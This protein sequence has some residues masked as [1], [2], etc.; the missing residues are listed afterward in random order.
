M[1][2]ITTIFSVIS[3]P[4][5]A[6]ELKNLNFSRPLYQAPTP[7][8]ASIPPPEILTDTSSIYKHPEKTAAIM[9]DIVI[10]ILEQIDETIYFSYLE[11]LTA[12]GPR[13]TGSEACQAAADYIYNQF[14]SM[15]LAVRYHHWSVG[16]HTSDNVEATINGIDESSDEIYIICAHYDT[17]S[18]SMGADDDASGTV[19]VLMAALIMSQQHYQFNH[20][21]K[22]VAFSGEEQGLLGSRMYAANATH[23]GWNIIGVLNADMISYAE[24][25]SDGNNLIVFRN[26]KSEWLYNYTVDISIEYADYIN[27]TLYDGGFTWGSD[28]YYFWDEGYDALF[29]FE[30]TE[31]PYYHTSGDTIAHI[32]TSYAVKNIRLILATLADLSEVS[33]PNSP[34]SK[35]V[36]TGPAKGAINQWYNFSVVAT[37]PEGEDVYYLIEW[38]D[39]QV[40]EWVGPYKSGI[41]IEITHVWNIKGTYTIKAKAKDINGIESDWGT[42]NVVMP[43]EYTFS[44]HELLQNLLMKFS[45]RFPIL[46]HIIQY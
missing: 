40:D 36:L 44:I 29:Y 28:H 1:L 17:V 46:Q 2:I 34:P 18:P 19:A 38:G 42:L 24:T 16:G 30:Y 13:V 8:Y 5:Q 37:E 25:T 15:G 20:T 4:A 7:G 39:G 45:D 22:F 10:S 6:G 32:N 23:E 31:T 11:N 27:L 12:F 9:N 33:I 26:D 41:T 14:E 35:P 21:I 43:K 3:F